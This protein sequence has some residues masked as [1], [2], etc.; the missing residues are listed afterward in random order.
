MDYSEALELL[1]HAGTKRTMQRKKVANNTYARLEDDGRVVIRLHATDIMEFSPAGIVRFD[2]GGWLTVTTKERMNRYGAPYRIH[3]DKGQWYVSALESGGYY[4]NP[5]GSRADSWREKHDGAEYVPPTFL[6][7]VPYFDG[8]ELE[9]SDP[10]GSLERAAGGSEALHA[11][12]LLE[13]DKE[14]KRAVSK[15][16]RGIS[17]DLVA[18]LLADA[19]ANGTAGDC[20]YC[21]HTTEGITIGDSFKDTEHLRSHLEE[22]YYMVSMMRD[23]LEEC[24]YRDPIFI[25]SI[26]AADIVRRAVRRYLEARLL[27]GASS[28]RRGSALHA[29]GWAG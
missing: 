16:V 12:E 13:T 20:L 19:Q 7:S 1:E 14:T 2:S 8:L 10:R 11:L 26:G 17:K 6:P 24:G 18:E 22:P 27:V 9:P 25:L 21:Q 15:Y 29:T 3:A 4:L 28:G 23:A 5:D